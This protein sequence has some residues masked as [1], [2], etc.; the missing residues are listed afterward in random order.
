MSLTKHVTVLRKRIN[1]KLHVTWILICIF[2]ML[3][4]VTNSSYLVTGQTYSRKVDID[5]L[6]ALAGLGASV[7]KVSYYQQCKVG[8]QGAT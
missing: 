4:F 6:A 7:H 3:L 5:V 2:P 1:T 8:H